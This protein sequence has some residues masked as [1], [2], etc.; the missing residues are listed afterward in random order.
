VLFATTT[1]SVT[2]LTDAHRTRQ[3]PHE[4][5][6]LRRYGL[7]II[8]E[9]GYLP[10]EQDAAN[11]FFQLVSSRYGAHQQPALLRLGQHG[12]RPL[13]HSQNQVNRATPV[14]AAGQAGQRAAEEL[15]GPAQD[16]LLPGPGLRARCRSSDSHDR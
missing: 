9:L 10:F 4:Q 1:D 6:K 12:Y 5:G 8:D 15:A 16:P 7:I 13:S 3:L 11:L 14:S 2:G